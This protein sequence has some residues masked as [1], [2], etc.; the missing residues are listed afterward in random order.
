MSKRDRRTDP[1]PP[2]HR[3]NPHVRLAPE[4][5]AQVEALVANPPAPPELLRLAVEPLRISPP[6]VEKWWNNLRR[7]WMTGPADAPVLVDPQPPA[8]TFAPHPGDALVLHSGTVSQVPP[9]VK[10]SA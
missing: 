5:L 7:A 1:I 6:P 2:E 4:Q 8:P 3:I 9:S 10:V